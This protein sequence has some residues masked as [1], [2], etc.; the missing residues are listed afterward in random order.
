MALAAKSCLALVTD[1]DQE[2]KEVVWM[3]TGEK[4]Q[5]EQL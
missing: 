3:A 5:A 1:W 2:M 4:E